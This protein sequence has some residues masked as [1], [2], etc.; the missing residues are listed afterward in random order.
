MKPVAVSGPFSPFWVQEVRRRSRSRQGYSR[1]GYKD[2]RERCFLI[3][4][5]PFIDN[6][7]YNRMKL[8]ERKALPQHC[9]GV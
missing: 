5:F 4:L 7:M 3:G 2:T 9:S 8:R 6:R 1:Q